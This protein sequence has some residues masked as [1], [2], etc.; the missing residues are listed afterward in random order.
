[1]VSTL[2]YLCIFLI[3]ICHFS[4]I[5]TT[6][7][8]SWKWNLGSFLETNPVSAFRQGNAWFLPRF[9]LCWTMVICSI[10]V[11]LTNALRS[12]T[13]SITVL[14]FLTGCGH[15]VHHCSSYAAAAAAEWP[16]LHLCR[17]LR[18]LVFVYKSF[19]GLLPSSLC[20]YMCKIENQYSLRSQNILQ[21]LVPGVRT[22][23]GKKAFK[24][25]APNSGSE[26]AW[27]GH[28]GRN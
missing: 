3:R 1:M 9:Y 14:L 20:T 12:W 19:L 26:T 7:F 23:W 22:D 4:H 24:Y 27:T 13:L 17:L 25:A 8:L 11:H 16:S 5:S 6:L 28:L 10:R 15:F 21:M 18:W 2:K